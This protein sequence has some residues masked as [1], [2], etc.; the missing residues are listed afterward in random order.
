[1]STL[2]PGVYSCVHHHCPFSRAVDVLTGH[3]KGLI[4]KE[5]STVGTHS[6]MNCESFSA[7]EEKW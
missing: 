2:F 1:M 4:L 3:I 6:Q 5:L 7:F